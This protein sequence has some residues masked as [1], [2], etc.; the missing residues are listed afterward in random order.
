MIMQYNPQDHVS[1]PTSVAGPVEC[2]Y[3]R[4]TSYHVKG[5]EHIWYTPTTCRDDP[6]TLESLSW[7][8]GRGKGRTPEGIEQRSWGLK[9][10]EYQRLD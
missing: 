6:V 5:L 2:W 4:A 9:E 10:S 1:E 3:S 7:V 8:K